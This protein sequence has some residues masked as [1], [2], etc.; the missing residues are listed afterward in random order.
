MRLSH[1]NNANIYLIFFFL[2]FTSVR[3][4]YTR[5]AE[6]TN[7]ES[8]DS[9]EII[10]TLY[11]N[12]TVR[13]TQIPWKHNAFQPVGHGLNLEMDVFFLISLLGEGANQ[14]HVSSQ[15]LSI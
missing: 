10:M 6:R 12:N 3:D 1:E 8:T 4:V 13:L 5:P 9:V 7:G 2:L 14:I 11:N 15:F